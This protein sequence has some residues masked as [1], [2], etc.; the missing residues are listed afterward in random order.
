MSRYRQLPLFQTAIDLALH[1]EQAVRRFP[2]YH[3]YT[4][5]TELRQA[6]Q[7]LCRLVGRAGSARCRVAARTAG[8]AL[9][10]A[11]SLSPF[12]P[13]VRRS[14]GMTRPFPLIVAA[15]AA[16]LALAAPAH[17]A[18][19]DNGDGTVTDTVTGLVWDQCSRGQ[20]WASTTTPKCSGTV[21]T[22]TWANA[23]AEADAANA[24]THRGF[25]DW[26]LPNRTELESLIDI[27]QSN[28]ATSAGFS[29]A[30]PATPAAYYWSSTTYAP[31]AAY[32]WFV[33][34]GDGVAY[35]FYKANTY[36]VRLVRSG[37]SFAPFDAAR[38][39]LTVTV[40]GSG[41]VSAGTTPAP[42]SGSIS[43][44]TSAGGA[45]C[46]AQ[47]TYNATTPASVTLT[48]TVPAG[49][50]V[51]WGG[52]CSGTASTCTV[53]MDQV[54][55]VTAAFAALPTYAVT[56]AASPT[57][58][59]SVSCPSAPVT[60]GQTAQCTAVANTGY[61]LTGISGCDGAASTT[62]PYTTG[63]IAA[64]CAVT[65]TFTQNSY[66]VTGSASPPAGG[67]VA[68][69]SS[70]VL[71][72][73][74]TSCTATPSSGYALTGISGCG[75]AASTTS[76]YTTGAITAACTVTATFTANGTTTYSGTT[77]PP[78]GGTPMPAS[79]SF[80]GGGSTCGFDSANTA[81]IAGT[82]PPPGKTLPQGMFKFRLTGCDV[83]STVTMSVT[84][85]QPVSQY[86]KF[87]RASVGATTDTWF[88][89]PGLALAGNTATFTITDGGVGDSD[90][91]AGVIADPTAV[92][93]D[94]GG[95]A[96]GAVAAVPT[97]GEWGLMLLGLLAAGFGARRLRRL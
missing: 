11:R 16:L 46:A 43:G 69:P 97:L 73:Q 10:A 74:P 6:A 86:G 88:T 40:T 21:G 12:N 9:G 95:G 14:L 85:P 92:L 41:S 39:A 7:R 55:S 83:G 94:A 65:A 78:A 28:T 30:F 90:A 5:G 13:L 76:P 66:A 75:G 17:A 62:S 68:C 84:W 8:V 24:A 1:L 15:A 25:K 44:C 63:A 77:V 52:A 32:A 82:T 51:T 3:K 93:A 48:A 70:P 81:F 72:G 22:F 80:S 89:P 2:R 53:T 49:Q 34:F 60:Q 54:R 50:Q 59:G 91:A 33:Y 29:D 61:T 67:V 64:A 36:R 35:T 19:A 79:A 71:Y 58:G 31:D 18:F 26:R 47:Y 56:G 38:R 87:G 20:T 57:A 37:Q 45:A 4:L 42:A 23:L 27:T 96:V